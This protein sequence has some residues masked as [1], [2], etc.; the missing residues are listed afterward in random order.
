MSWATR[1]YI[2]EFENEEHKRGY[3]DKELQA[4]ELRK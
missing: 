1:R 2:R 3:S 4:A